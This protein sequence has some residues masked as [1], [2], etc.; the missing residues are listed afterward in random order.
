MRRWSTVFLLCFVALVAGLGG[1][2]TWKVM[3]RRAPAPPAQ[4]AAQ[5]DY[6]IKEIHI[7]ETL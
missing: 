4:P 5:A 6:Q 1:V 2:V 3:G 7:N